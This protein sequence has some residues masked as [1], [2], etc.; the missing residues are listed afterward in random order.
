MH[1]HNHNVVH[2]DLKPEN[3]LFAR[4]PPPPSSSCPARHPGPSPSLHH[5]SFSCCQ[6][7]VLNM[8]P[9]S[10][11]FSNN[12]SS[13]W[14]S[15]PPLS[16][17]ACHEHVMPRC[18]CEGGPYQRHPPSSSCASAACGCRLPF[19]CNNSPVPCDHHLLRCSSSSTCTGSADPSN[20]SAPSHLVQG[21]H[22]HRHGGHLQHSCWPRVERT[23]RGFDNVTDGRRCWCSCSSSSGPSFLFHPRSTPS[24]QATL[25][26]VEKRHEDEEEDLVEVL[27]SQHNSNCCSR[28]LCQ[29][30]LTSR[31]S[32]EGE[33]AGC[34]GGGC[35]RACRVGGGDA[36]DVKSQRLER[37][38][39]FLSSATVKI[40]DFGAAC[41]SARGQ[42]RGTACG[43]VHYVSLRSFRL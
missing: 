7:D 10:K 34:W 36:S 32:D 30:G 40:V 17:C 26:C 16:T 14:R 35:C 11:N 21:G 20:S 19:S 13:A 27:N 3:I 33:G 23:C 22:H 24:S 12:S 42:L 43:T 28:R 41:A 29:R 4:N 1:C 5:S 15:S 25:D 39:E 2:R 18:C 37:R 8:S 6:R 9:I 38:R 31:R